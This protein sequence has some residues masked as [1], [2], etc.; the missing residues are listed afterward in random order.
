[1]KSHDEAGT[2]ICIH[3]VCIDPTYRRQGKGLELLTTYLKYL[4]TLKHTELIL[5]I[6]KEYLIPFYMKC[7]FEL[8][9]ISTIVHGND[10]W[11][12]MRIKN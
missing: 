8:V 10:Q 11:Y 4:K 6:T 5:L 2:T 12:E 1:M 3:S 7:G 9:G